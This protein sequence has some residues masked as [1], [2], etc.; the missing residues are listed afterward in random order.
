MDEDFALGDARPHR[1]PL[2]TRPRIPMV[3][4]RLP[5]DIDVAIAKVIAGRVVDRLIAPAARIASPPGAGDHRRPPPAV[6]PDAVAKETM[7]KEN[8]PAEERAE[9]AMKAD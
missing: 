9:A 5:A 7:M 4:A 6:D 1:L 8:P 2:L 3:G